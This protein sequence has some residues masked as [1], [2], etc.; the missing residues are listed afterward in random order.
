M[1]RTATVRATRPVYL[2]EVSRAAIR[3][4]IGLD[5]RILKLLMRFFRARLVG[6]H[7]Q[8]SE[9]FR[10]FS[11]DEK[12]RLV[13]RF[14]L[15]EVG[16]D[17]VVVREAQKGE[18]LFLVL[19]GRLEVTQSTAAAGPAGNRRTRA[20]THGESIILGELGPGDVFGEMSLLEGAQTMATVRTTT[21]AWVLFLPAAEFQDLAQ[22]HPSV[23][24]HLAA[25]ADRRREQNRQALAGT[26][27]EDRVE[28]V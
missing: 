9:L 28:P 19:V 18:G 7:L 5:R 24:D 3:Q 16:A 23:R 10:R 11:R 26:F 15:R 17:S 2:L 8:T 12:R 4:M 27:R 22:Q 14:R 1:P 21:R 13:S 6:T 20:T 25:I